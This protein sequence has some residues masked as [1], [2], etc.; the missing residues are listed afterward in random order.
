[1]PACVPARRAPGASRR[2]STALALLAAGALVLGA[3]GGGSDT[4]N[5]ATLSPAAA[6]RVKGSLEAVGVK[7]A[8]VACV[9]RKIVENADG[10]DVS[11]LGFPDF[12]SEVSPLTRE[13]LQ[14]A[15]AAAGTASK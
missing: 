1:M 11:Q 3:C 2:R 10:Q 14:E 13:C 12:V 5:T 9:E 8:I 7:P 15:K 6:E 4:T